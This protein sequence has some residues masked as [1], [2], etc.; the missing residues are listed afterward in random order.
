MTAISN[1]NSFNIH[2][3]SHKYVRYHGK[4][5]LLT[6]R[7]TK[8]KANGLV[9]KQLIHEIAFSIKMSKRYDSHTTYQYFRAIKI[10]LFNMKQFSIISS[11]RCMLMYSIISIFATKYHWT[12]IIIWY[13]LYFIIKRRLNQNLNSL[14]RKGMNEVRPKW[15]Y[16]FLKSCLH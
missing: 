1:V 11:S 13:K 9:D 14:W 10:F 5:A 6:T 2:M 8:K 3:V 12:M 4:L 7:C 15:E 16:N